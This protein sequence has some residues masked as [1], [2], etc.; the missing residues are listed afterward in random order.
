MGELTWAR[1]GRGRGEV[2]ARLGRGRARVRQPSPGRPPQHH[3][4]WPA[5]PLARLRWRRQPHMCPNG[6]R[7]LPGAAAKTARA[8][9]RR[10]RR[11]EHMP[12]RAR[13]HRKKVWAD[14]E[15]QT[16]GGRQPGGGTGI[17]GQTWTKSSAHAIASSAK[18]AASGSSSTLSPSGLSHHAPRPAAPR[19]ASHLM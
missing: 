1:S 18:I 13:P 2:G 10:S 16:A 6:K 19:T 4:N 12:C 11:V 8:W 17:W 7:A 3:R 9:S 15:G 5:P 14:R